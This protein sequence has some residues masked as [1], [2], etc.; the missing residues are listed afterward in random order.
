MPE[1]PVLDVKPAVGRRVIGTS[2]KRV[3][4][5]PLR[6]SPRAVIPTFVRLERF[7][8][9][10]PSRGLPEL[11]TEALTLSVDRSVIYP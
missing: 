3:S 5:R 1:R 7:S 4:A 10:F 6:K 11:D 2:R 8:G 9:P